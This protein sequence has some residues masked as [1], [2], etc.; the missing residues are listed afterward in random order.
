MVVTL[1]VGFLI[2][3]VPVRLKH[4][5]VAEILGVLYVLWS[6]FHSFVLYENPDTQDFE[7]GIY[8]VLLWLDN[9]GQALWASLGMLLLVVPLATLVLWYILFGGATMNRRK[10]RLNRAVHNRRRRF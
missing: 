1:M 2:N 3:R 8:E 6:V 9:H 4:A 10:P 5:H 7:G